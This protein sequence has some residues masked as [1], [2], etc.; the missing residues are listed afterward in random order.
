MK[1]LGYTSEKTSVLNHLLLP[2]ALL[3][4]AA[5]LGYVVATMGIFGIAII[6]GGIVSLIFFQKPV[7]GYF[8]TL[9]L[10]FI[11]PSLLPSV[12]EVSEFTIRFVDFLFAILIFRLVLD[13]FVKN[14]F[15]KMPSLIIPIILFMGYIALSVMQVAV[16]TPDRFAISLASYLR[17]LE[18]FLLL[19]ITYFVFQRERSLKKL[20]KFI[21]VAGL[22]SILIGA[23]EW[24]Q[25]RY[26]HDVTLLRIRTSGFLGINSFGLV[27]GLLV[28]L[29]V[30]LKYQGY[31]RH[32]F[33][34][35][36][37]IGL[38]LSRSASSAVATIISV[39]FYI[40]YRRFKAGLR[41]PIRLVFVGV[42]VLCIA[43]LVVW[44]IRPDD[45]SGIF[46]LT[47]GSFAHRLYLANAGF[48]IFLE[49]PHIGI[50]WQGSS[51]PEVIGASDINTSLRARFFLFP[52]QYFA[53]VN[54]TSVHNLYIQF[55]AEFGLVGFTVFLVAAMQVCQKVRRFVKKMP[56]RAYAKDLTSFF[57]FSLIFLLIWWNTNPLFG[58]QIETVLFFT[59]LGALAAMP[60]IVRTDE[61]SREGR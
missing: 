50:G 34:A 25:M 10:F 15:I 53:D 48:H 38:L 1:L 9:A 54:P 5:M 12:F 61:R 17:L 3:F 40:G 6:L 59:F 29:G 22:I 20:V 4:G 51:A 46:N 23:W 13:S 37:F 31:S 33:I 24:Y 8:A 58:G 42:V 55:L 2:L 16:I 52:E 41:Y 57:A 7:Y 56:E 28:L 30:I 11:N 45:V 19:P 27:S 39:I 35:A 18:T 43:A 47:G 21:A 36:G 49:H 14:S 26:V 60:K 32:L 44:F